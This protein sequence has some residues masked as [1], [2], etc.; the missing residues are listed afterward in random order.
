MYTYIMSERNP[1]RRTQI[2]LDEDI[3]HLLEKES[4][5]KNI[6]ISEIIRRSIREKIQIRKKELLK[7]MDAVYGIWNDRTKDVEQYIRDIRKDRRR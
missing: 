3:F 5:I 6:S 7:K 1:M 2:Y 4:K